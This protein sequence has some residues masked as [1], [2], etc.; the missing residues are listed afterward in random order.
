MTPARPPARGKHSNAKEI[1]LQSMLGLN[2]NEIEILMRLVAWGSLAR[3]QI[4]AIAT[5]GHRPVKISSVNA[6]IGGLRRKLANHGIGLNVVRDF[7]WALRQEDREKIVAL[8]GPRQGL[9]VN[10]EA[11]GAKNLSAG[12]MEPETSQTHPEAA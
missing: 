5:C 4:P 6:I 1:T 2:R 9:G 12:S 3:E 7:G 8:I 11:A 10:T